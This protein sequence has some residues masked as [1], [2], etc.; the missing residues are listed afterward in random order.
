MS[1]LIPQQNFHNDF[2]Y[3]R[4]NLAQYFGIHIR[5]LETW[6]KKKPIPWQKSGPHQSCG[7]RIRLDVA[8]FYYTNRNK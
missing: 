3:G 2:I 4:K 8:D 6:H 7:I 1:K 5:T